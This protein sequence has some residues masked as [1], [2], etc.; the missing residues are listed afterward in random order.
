MRRAIPLCGFGL[1]L[2]LWYPGDMRDPD[3]IDQFQQSLAFHFTDW[4]PPVMALL[5]SGLNALWTGPQLML[6]VQLGLYWGSVYFVLSSVEQNVPRRYFLLI[7][8][9][10]CAPY[11][12][13]FL[14]DIVKDVQLLCAWTF[15]VTFVFWT[16]ASGREPS[17]LAKGLMLVLVLYGGL[18]RH[19]SGLVAAP[20]MLYVLHGRPYLRRA[21]TTVAS[22]VLVA[23]AVVALGRGLNAGL[24]VETTSIARIGLAFDV[25]G[26]STRV[27]AN[28]LPFTL[29][30]SEFDRI[31]QCYDGAAQDVFV[32]GDCRFV[33]SYVDASA[34]RP[35]LAAWVDAVTAHPLAYGA[36]RLAVFQ[37]FAIKRADESA[38]H[39]L[40]SIFSR[41]I[42]YIVWLAAL[43][44]YVVHRRARADSPGWRGMG[45]SL[46]WTEAI[47]SVL[48][49]ATYVP[50]GV[51]W[52][53]RYIYLVVVAV[54][55]ATCGAITA[56]TAV[57]G[58]GSVHPTCL[59]RSGVGSARAPR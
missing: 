50:F 55:L 12:A 19:N 48:Y 42:T 39:V 36:H 8:G 21:W 58:G 28:L 16:R 3:S 52:G 29:S 24:H 32:W 59:P 56:F 15:A 45:L 7:A 13:I 41:P 1:T 10:L 9:L 47:V 22:Y 34:D 30:A 53:F 37:H 17:R 18:V 5:W 27:D 20:V 57:S 38:G 51:A 26:I 54:S 49:L 2:I 43:L 44:A 23:A 14:G 6:I 33:R 4:H 11:I 25:A 31:K 35:M 46:F 40:I